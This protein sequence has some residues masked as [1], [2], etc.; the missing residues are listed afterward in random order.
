MGVHTIY[1]LVVPLMCTASGI[2]HWYQFFWDQLVCF[3]TLNDPVFSTQRE[4]ESSDLPTGSIFSKTLVV[5][6]Q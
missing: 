4:E 5:S 1:M 3:S 6:I 2:Q